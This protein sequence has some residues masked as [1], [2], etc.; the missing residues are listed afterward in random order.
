M[1]KSKYEYV[2]AFEQHAVALLN[3][4]IVVRVDG[5]S[6]HRFTSQHGFTKPNDERGLR[7]AN[8][9]ACA[10][11]EEV[12]D[13]FLA[14][15]QSDEFSFAFRKST[16]LYKRRSEK[17]M[18]TIVSLF[19]GHYIV[20]WP[21]FFPGKPLEYP[22]SF[23][24]RLVMYPSEKNLKDYFSW[25][26]AD[27]H[28][29]NLDPDAPMTE[30]AA[31]N[32]LKDTNSASKNELLFKRFSINYNQLPEI[33]RK[34]SVVVRRKVGEER[35]RP[36]GTKFVKEVSRVV[37]ENVDLIT[38]F[39]WDDIFK[40]SEVERAKGLTAARSRASVDD[41]VA[42]ERWAAATKRSCNDISHRPAVVV[43]FMTSS[44]F[45]LSD[46]FGAPLPQVPLQPSSANPRGGSPGTDPK[47]ATGSPHLTL[48]DIE[49]FLLSDP[50]D[51]NGSPNFNFPASGGQQNRQQG[52]KFGSPPLGNPQQ[53]PSP[54]ITNSDSDS[55]HG[56]P[57]FPFL[58]GAFGQSTPS[59]PD[60]STTTTAPAPRAPA[61]P[62]PASDAPSKRGRKRKELTDEQQEEKNRERMMKNRE[63]AQS[64]RDKKRRYVEELE[65]HNR[66]LSEQNATLMSRL[67]DMAGQIAEMRSLMRL[68]GAVPGGGNAG[69]LAQ[70][71]SSGKRSPGGLQLIRN[72]MYPSLNNWWG[73]TIPAR[74]PSS[75]SS[76]STSSTSS[77]A[78]T[79]N[80]GL[81]WDRDGLTGAAVF[82][83]PSSNNNGTL[84][85][86]QH[87]DESERMS[88]LSSLI[89]PAA[90]VKLG[91]WGVFS[92]GL[93]P[94]MTAVRS[95]LY[96]FFWGRTGKE[97]LLHEA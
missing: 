28:I 75:S 66:T 90:K 21:K 48:E 44:I 71:I 86:G 31:Q 11:M 9:A 83:P 16:T 18:S 62:A 91:R 72:T 88:Q 96:N 13:V 6:F 87:V 73:I 94:N 53:Q 40:D 27:C 54:V 35:G 22:P 42:A 41:G 7:L 29:N 30:I 69:S 3:T 50:E 24:G 36:D 58:F 51:L 43:D 97:R 38:T 12:Q 5:H 85:G 25:R 92:T 74:S 77:P 14:Y 37:V 76:S 47:S 59:L 89:P 93:F 45:N 8:Y 56:S 82:P 68:P 81:V 52:F 10:V 70:V 1:A 95:G 78:L 55:Q 23:D 20:G 80:S 2:K 61:K 26:Q 84:V 32:F 15:G 79:R 67:E 39:N 46:L 17:I 49:Q 65:H 4:Y 19:T 60:L 64:S 34:G 57:V 63:A 33:Y